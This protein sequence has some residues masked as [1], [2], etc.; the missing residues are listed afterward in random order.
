VR[1]VVS[2]SAVNIERL[3][4]QRCPVDTG[5]LRASVA[6]RFAGETAAEIGTNVE[7]APYVEHGTRYQRAQPFLGPA[8]EQERPQFLSALAAVIRET[9]P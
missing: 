9:R 7:Y 2:I 8:L 5:R 6:K 3:A 1:R 4:K